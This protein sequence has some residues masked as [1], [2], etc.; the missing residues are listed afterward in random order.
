MS[1]EVERYLAKLPLE[2]RIALHT[3]RETIRSIVP[4]VEE[5][6]RDRR[7]TFDVKGD[8]LAALTSDRHFMSLHV[9]EKVLAE[10]AAALSHLQCGKSCIRFRRVEDLP[11]K[12]VKRILEDTLARRTNGKAA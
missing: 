12:V 11:L 10:H 6:I 5:T 8:F 4:E 1:V 2:R 3:V 7:P 9:D